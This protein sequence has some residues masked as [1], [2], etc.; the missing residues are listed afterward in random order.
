MDTP[1]ERSDSGEE[2]VVL[3]STYKPMN[4]DAENLKND[5]YP[6]NRSFGVCFSGGGIRS[7]SFCSGVLQAMAFSKAD[8][9]SY[10]SKLPTGL[11]YLVNMR[12]LSCVSGGGFTGSSYMTHLKRSIEKHGLETGGPAEKRAV[13]KVLKKMKKN[14]NYLCTSTFKL[15]VMGIALAATVVRNYTIL[16]AFCMILALLISTACGCYDGEGVPS[17]C[18]P[19]ARLCPSINPNDLNEDSNTDNLFAWTLRMLLAL[20]LLFLACVALYFAM[21]ILRGIAGFLQDRWREALLWFSS[22]DQHEATPKP[23]RVQFDSTSANSHST[24]S[25]FS[26]T[27][28]ICSNGWKNFFH[29]L[30]RLDWTKGILILISVVIIAG[31]T[32]PIKTN[33]ATL[34]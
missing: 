22:R 6:R 16:L 26:Q 20:V 30:L 12:Y 1:E 11:D 31:S 10:N 9:D 17:S 15:V 34:H 5:K 2:L 25:S 23:H 18:S 19:G 13:E 27:L 4:Y 24:T 29:K 32:I 14:S 3:D 33:R 8:N 7:A 28:R 21:A